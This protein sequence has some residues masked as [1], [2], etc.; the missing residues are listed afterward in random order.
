MGCNVHFLRGFRF[1]ST[2][3]LSCSSVWPM[4]T[5]PECVALAKTFTLSSLPKSLKQN[6][7]KVRGNVGNY[8]GLGSTVAKG[9]CREG[10]SVGLALLAAG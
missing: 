4:S 3:I 1:V 7:C 6:G 8:M 5:N 2:V 9:G 10:R